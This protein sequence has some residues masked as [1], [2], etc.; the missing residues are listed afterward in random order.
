MLLVHT[1]DDTMTDPNCSRYM[2]ARLPNSRLT[3]VPRGDDAAHTCLP[4]D[5]WDAAMADLRTAAT[6]GALPQGA[7]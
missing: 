2:H 4:R 6:T 1:R 7:L 5:V 3:L